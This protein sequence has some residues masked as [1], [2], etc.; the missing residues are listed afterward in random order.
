MT[1][2]TN[3]NT[4]IAFLGVGRMGSPMATRLVAAGFLV[5][6][7]NRS[8][9]RVAPLVEAG[10]VEAA[11]SAEAAIGADFLVTMLPDGPSVEA[12]MSG[13]QGALSTLRSGAV[14]LQ[15]SSIGADWT[16]RLSEL[17]AHSGV[18]F[19]DAPVSGSVGPAE[20]GTLLVL[21]GGPIEARDQVAP[22]LDAMSRQ[23]VWLGPVGAGSKA[24]L[25]LNNW[26]VDLVEATAETL[27]FSEALGL[28]P[29]LII[30]LLDEAPIGSPYAVGKA[31][32]MLAGEFAPS[33]AL[34]HALKDADL[35][36]AAGRDAGIELR[37]TE[38]F[39]GSWHRAVANGRGEQD[40]SVVFT[41]SEP[42]RSAQ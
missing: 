40:L 32:Q 33:F 42:D 27:H 7:W 38:S 10:A 19:V 13:A 9:Q 21:A 28:D 24:K 29:Q 20:A 14:W 15:M 12:V 8:P 1:M 23:T 25:V 39:I 30:G 35:S 22:V 6:V 26:L 37:V 2:R 5:R 3:S 36:V 31:R 16:N 11:S 41:N 18:L 34:K 4:T 17:A